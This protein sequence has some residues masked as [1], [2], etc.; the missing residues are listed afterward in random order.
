MNIEWREDKDLP[1][2]LMR[3]LTRRYRLVNAAAVSQN[4]WLVCVCW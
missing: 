1:I 4:T 3:H 2:L